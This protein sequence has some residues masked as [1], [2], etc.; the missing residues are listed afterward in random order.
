ME[1]ADNS[2]TPSFIFGIIA[3]IVGGA[4]YKQFDFATLRFANPWL[5]IVYALTFSAAIYWLIKDARNKA[6]K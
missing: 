1:N 5:A 3:I 2:K 4:L 6:Q